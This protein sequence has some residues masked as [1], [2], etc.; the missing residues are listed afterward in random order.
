MSNQ[1]EYELMTLDELGM[2]YV[3]NKEVVKERNSE[4]KAIKSIIDYRIVQTKKQQPDA[5]VVIHPIQSTI[6]PTKQY[7]IKV[8]QA[9]PPTIVLPDIKRRP[10]PG[11]EETLTA[12][13]NERGTFGT[14]SEFMQWNKEWIASQT[15][16][17]EDEYQHAKEIAIQKAREEAEHKTVNEEPKWKVTFPPLKPKKESS[18]TKQT[19]AKEQKIVFESEKGKRKKAADGTGAKKRRKVLDEDGDNI[20]VIGGGGGGA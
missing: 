14:V 2:L 5:P 17:I 4:N 9:P 1:S 3:E 11:I 10:V 19:K 13:I 12:Y 16:L 20:S 18:S 8:A 15:K 6:E 7:Q